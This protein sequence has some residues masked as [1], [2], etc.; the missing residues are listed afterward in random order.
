MTQ[1][2]IIPQHQTKDSAG[3]DLIANET[4][5]INQGQIELIPTGT[6]VP[7]NLPENY[8]LGLYI[9]S[10]IAYKKGLMLANSVG[11]IDRDYPDEIKVML[12]N[13]GVVPVTIEKGERIA[14]LIA[15]TY[16]NIFPVK[17]SKRCG[18]FGSTNG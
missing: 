1:V 5:T 17:Q 2:K 12:Y 9:R 10:S 14:Q 18:G 16:I 3:A 11:I 8:F 4:V 15:Q 13:P 6:Y 7:C